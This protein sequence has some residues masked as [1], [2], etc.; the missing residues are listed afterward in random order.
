MNTGKKIDQWARIESSE[1]NPSM[2]GTSINN[3][4][5]IIV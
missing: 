5:G 1:I 2:N 3:R 4:G